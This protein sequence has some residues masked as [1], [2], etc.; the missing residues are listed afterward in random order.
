MPIFISFV[1]E[2]PQLLAEEALLLLIDWKS[3]E[4][5]RN[6]SIGTL[7]TYSLISHF[8]CFQVSEF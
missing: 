1:P 5:I 8:I 7:F 4:L 2:L 3:A 6:V